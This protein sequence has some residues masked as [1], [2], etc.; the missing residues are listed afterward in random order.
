LFVLCVFAQVRNR[1]QPG[2]PAALAGLERLQ[3]ELSEDGNA[4]EADAGDDGGDQEDGGEPVRLVSAIAAAL[5]LRMAGA[6][7]EEEDA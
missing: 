7:D 6:Q 4:E 1:I 2:F 3:G 5:E